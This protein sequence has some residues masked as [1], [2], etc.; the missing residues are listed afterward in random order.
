MTQNIKKELEEFYAY[1]FANKMGYYWKIEV[2][3]DEVNYPD[4]IVKTQNEN[5][6]LEMTL[7][8][9]DQKSKRGSKLKQEEENSDRLLRKLAIK[10]YEKKDSPIYV[11]VNGSLSEGNL[12]KVL[13]YLL[14]TDVKTYEIKVRKIY[15]GAPFYL[16]ITGL[17]LI[18]ANYSD[19][20]N[21]KDRIGFVKAI[22]K[23]EIEI[24]V[25]EK[26]K[27]LSKYS[28]II[29]PVSLLIYAVGTKNSGFLELEN[30]EIKLNK[31]GFKNVYVYI[32][33]IQGYKF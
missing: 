31:Y 4:L 25:S 10:Y 5:F 26:S 20:Q 3:P 6:G 8:F 16:Y 11:K 24:K 13:D 17:P 12:E 21:I 1:Q 22:S 14:K 27:N 33:P 19:W 32:H 2:P 29:N 9:K 28:R 23:D 18:L 7:L 15:D 30:V